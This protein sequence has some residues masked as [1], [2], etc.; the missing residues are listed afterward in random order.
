MV[1]LINMNTRANEYLNILQQHFDWNVRIESMETETE[2]DTTWYEIACYVPE[3]VKAE[4]NVK[5]RSHDD[6]DQDGAASVLDL[7]SVGVGETMEEAVCELFHYCYE[8][9]F[10]E[11]E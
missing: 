9:G 6:F 8:N 3:L 2:W 4:L 10:L 5:K 11:D 7:D 1:M